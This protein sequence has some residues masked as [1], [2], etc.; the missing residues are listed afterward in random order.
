MKQANKAGKA[1][2]HALCD[3]STLNALAAVRLG[4]RWLT[5]ARRRQNKA[6]LRVASS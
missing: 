6:E 3:R 4:K 1:V 2:N 5:R